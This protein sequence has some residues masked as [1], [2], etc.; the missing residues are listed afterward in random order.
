[1]HLDF[2]QLQPVSSS[3]RDVLIMALTSNPLQIPLC[4]YLHLPHSVLHTSLLALLYRSSTLVSYLPVI[5][6]PS[7]PHLDNT[8]VLCLLNPHLLRVRV[9]HSLSHLWKDIIFNVF[10]FLQPATFLNEPF[11]FTLRYVTIQALGI[12]ALNISRYLYQSS[13]LWMINFI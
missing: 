11:Q 13:M 3:Q 10:I 9:S 12:S 2:S 7:P 1:M 6:S 5:L 4:L 8:F